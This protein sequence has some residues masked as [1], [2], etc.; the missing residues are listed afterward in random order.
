MSDEAR[1]TL[2]AWLGITTLEDALADHA[3]RIRALELAPA[4]PDHTPDITA[5]QGKAADHEARLRVL[6]LAPPP[7]IVPPDDPVPPEPDPIITPPPAPPPSGW[8]ARATTPPTP[9]RWWD[10]ASGSDSNDGLTRATAWKSLPYA[11]A[12]TLSASG[13]NVLGVVPKTYTVATTGSVAVNHGSTSSPSWRYYMAALENVHAPAENRL[14]IMA[15]EAQER[16]A[17]FLTGGIGALRIK[18]CSYITLW[19]LTARSADDANADRANS[20]I[21]CGGSSHIHTIRCLVSKANNAGNQ[22]CF[23]NTNSQYAYLEECEAYDTYRHLYAFQNADHFH[24]RRCY[25]NGRSA[26]ALAG[27]DYSAGSFFRE[28]NAYRARWG[29][30]ENCVLEGEAIHPI[31]ADFRTQGVVG[32]GHLFYGGIMFGA[33]R[34]FPTFYRKAGSHYLLKFKHMV[35]LEHRS[36]TWNSLATDTKYGSDFAWFENFTI[37]NGTGGAIR[38]DTGS[39]DGRGAAEYEA[40]TGE[41]PITWRTQHKNHVVWGNAFGYVELKNTG[42]QRTLSHSLFYDNGGTAPWGGSIEAGKTYSDAVLVSNI[43]TNSLN[44]N[45]AWGTF[46]VG[47]DKSVV[48]VPSGHPVLE[49]AGDGVGIDGNMG[50]TILYRHEGNVNASAPPT[51]NLTDKPLWNP[52]TGQFP[53]GAVIAGHNDQDAAGAYNANRSLHTFHT[54]IGMASA[55]VL[56]AAYPSDDPVPPDHRTRYLS[57]VGHD[58]AEH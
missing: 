39:F 48:F 26:V 57:P 40:L 51:E 11:A 31:Q 15:P 22:S 6:E 9:V 3:G 36:G 49:G 50:A 27:A 52:A 20:V 33:G 53:H 42:L 44:T 32:H 37:V 38:A 2:R 14:W 41:A 58:D 1:N 30:Y 43:F 47:T 24:V 17:I 34:A 29:L 10:P 54:R 23:G 5:L 16:E 21:G 7:I 28:V 4:P 56:A 45:P 55:T 13:P 35:A 8:V 12:Q 46:G 25:G 18:G 19:G